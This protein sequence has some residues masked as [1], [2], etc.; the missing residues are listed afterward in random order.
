MTAARAGA[1]T[2]PAA[3]IAIWPPKTIPKPG[4]LT[5][6][7]AATATI[8]A[9]PAMAARFQRTLSTIAPAGTWKTRAAM[10]D[11]DI[12]APIE[13][14]SHCWDTSSHMAR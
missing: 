13:A 12:T 7:M 3:P 4:V 14:G 9:A 2:A 1:K 10:P 8:I 5:V 11:T 6:A